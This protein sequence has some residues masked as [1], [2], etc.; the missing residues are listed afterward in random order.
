MEIRVSVIVAARNEENRIRACIESL[1]SVIG[2]LD[3]IIVVNDGST[4]GTARVL[5]QLRND[6][7]SVI[8][9]SESQGRAAS[10]NAAI[11]ASRGKYIAI[12]DAD[13]E[14]LPGRIEIPLLILENDEN[15]V[16]ASGQC[17]AVTNHGFAW[18]HHVYPTSRED[19]R[20]G[21]AF[22]NMAVCHTGSVIRRS[23]LDRAGLYNSDFVRAQDLELFKRLSLLGPIENSPLDT[24]I[25]RHDAWLTWDYWRLSR[26]HHDVIAGRAPLPLSVLSARYVIAM[27]RRVARMCS[28]HRQAEAAL[29]RARG[30]EL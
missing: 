6:V 14:A 24:I 20:K 13:D 4:D 21:F 26:K 22:S 5:S 29:A 9:H 28:S 23:A 7:V 17:V 10:R 30:A 18:R 1:L 2:P 19:I 3:E 12:Q 25:Y 11:E 15:L 16:A 8:T 27:L